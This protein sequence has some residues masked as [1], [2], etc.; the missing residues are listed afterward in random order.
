M[1]K[2][3][4]LVNV[5]NIKLWKRFSTKI[6]IIIM[7][8]VIVG[9]WGLEK[10]SAD[11]VQQALDAQ[12]KTSQSEKLDW[13]EGLKKDN[14]SLQAQID[15]AEKSKSFNEK[16]SLDQY[17]RQLAENKYRI[18]HNLKPE[19]SEY[20]NI[21]FLLSTMGLWQIVALFVIIATSALV[22]GE[23]SESTMKTMIPRPYA[24]WQILTAKFVS[25]LIYT[26]FMTVIGY[27]VAIGSACLFFGPSHLKGPVLL[28]IGGNIIEVSSVAAAFI[29][30]GL[31]LLSV[32]VYVILTFAICAVARSRALATGLAI[33]LMFG[34]SFTQLIAQHFS[35]GKYIF[36][37]DTNF[38]SFT[39][40]GSISYGLTLPFALII[41]A[42]YCIVFMFAGYFVFAK[43]DIS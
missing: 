19:K 14:Q 25:V 43:R 37:A 8:A 38:S 10:M 31:E 6:M 26:L 33:F 36:F 42:I 1:G 4:K 21:W 15:A 2:F 40:L 23:F 30:T 12:N 27:L 17:K 41:C 39:T 29:L 5:E 22:A 9:L 34:G 28:W 3:I 20:Y 35:W 11:M 13:K 18:E 24:R 16:S 7:V 32:L